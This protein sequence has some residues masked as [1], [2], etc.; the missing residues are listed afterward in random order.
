[1]LAGLLL[2]TIAMGCTVLEDFEDGGSAHWYAVNDKVMGG[3][4]S[5]EPLLRSGALVFE[6]RIDTN[7]GGFS[8]IRR[9]LPQSVLEGA[10]RIEVELV[11]DGRAYE[12]IFQTGEAFK[13]APVT[14][15]TPL[16]RGEHTSPVAAHLPLTEMRATL[17]GRPVPA[18][19]FDAGQAAEMGIMLADGQDGPFRLE[20]R[21]I[22]VCR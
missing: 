13:G 11:G 1:M 19:P 20:V 18:A 10:E 3:R 17:R 5:G 9:R 16:T 22:A 6:G 7:G 8:S 4:S 15:R 12:M 2:G 14:Y 21:R